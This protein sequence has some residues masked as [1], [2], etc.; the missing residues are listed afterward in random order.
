MVGPSIEPATCG[1]LVRHA[2]DCIMRPVRYDYRMCV[3]T[4][5]EKNGNQGSLLKVYLATSVKYKNKEYE[6]TTANV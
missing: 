1:S 6:K 3:V 5:N 4:V 2:S